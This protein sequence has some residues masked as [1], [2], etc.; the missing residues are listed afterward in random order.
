MRLSFNLLNF[1]NGIAI[2]DSVYVRYFARKHHNQMLN[3]DWPY[4]VVE[5]KPEKT[6]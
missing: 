2:R 1:V 3:Y 5:I 4:L 6:N